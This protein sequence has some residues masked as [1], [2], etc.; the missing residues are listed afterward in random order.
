MAGFKRA[1][2]HVLETYPTERTHEF[3]ENELARFIREDLRNAVDERFS[4]LDPMHG[5]VT[6]AA[7]G[8]ESGGEC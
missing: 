5:L 6:R 7:F 1:L 3:A 4:R 8:P 2:D